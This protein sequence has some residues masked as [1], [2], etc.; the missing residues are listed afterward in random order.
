MQ[1]F[2]K[3]FEISIEKVFQNIFFQYVSEIL[4]EKK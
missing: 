1:K 2:D 3:Q 4:K